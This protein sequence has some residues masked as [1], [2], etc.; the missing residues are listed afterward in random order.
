MPY[1]L[2][3]TLCE[4]AGPMRRFDSVLMSCA[5][6][7]AV[8]SAA[9]RQSNRYLQQRRARIVVAAARVGLHERAQRRVGAADHVGGGLAHA[10]DLRQEVGPRVR[11]RRV[12]LPGR[13]AT[14]L[15]LLAQ[16]QLS[17][18]RV[19]KN[20]SRTALLLL[21]ASEIA[22]SA[23]RNGACAM[24]LVTSTTNAAPSLIC[25]TCSGRM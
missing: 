8:S 25:C 6:V 12:A 3:K 18:G 23:S 17:W 16:E 4:M 22:F 1:K 20:D 19:C 9:S 15:T 10:L 24:L 21:L 13:R 7:I 11:Q 2:A 5:R 14:T